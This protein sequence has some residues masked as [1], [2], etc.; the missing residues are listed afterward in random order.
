MVKITSDWKQTASMEDL[1]ELMWY[2]SLGLLDTLEIK[3]PMY[4]KYNRLL[5]E[6][7]NK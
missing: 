3:W 5:D 7:W 6:I 4:V 2:E 1:S